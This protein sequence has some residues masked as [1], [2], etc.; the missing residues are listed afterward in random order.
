MDTPPRNALQ[1][2]A[3]CSKQIIPTVYTLLHVLATLLVTTASSERSFSTHRRLRTYLRNT[4]GEERLNGLVVMQVHRDINVSTG[5][6][7]TKLLEKPRRLG[8]CLR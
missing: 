6:I 3:V 2:L 7:L 1:A 8:I 5:D 4:T